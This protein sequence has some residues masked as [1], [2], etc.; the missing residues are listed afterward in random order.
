MPSWPKAAGKPRDD[1]ELRA[2]SSNAEARDYTAP[3]Y[4]EQLVDEL[5]PTQNDYNNAAWF[6][7]FAAT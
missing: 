3:Q 6:E 5:S 2:L 7:L 1:E 4:A